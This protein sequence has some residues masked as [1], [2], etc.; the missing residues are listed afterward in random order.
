M[1]RALRRYAFRIMHREYFYVYIMSNR[2]RTLYT[3][4]TNNLQKRV[5][6]H[7]NHVYEGFTDRYQCDRLVY[8]EQLSTPEGGINREKQIKG[9]KRVRKV[10]LI[11]AQNPTWRDLS[12]DW[13]KPAQMTWCA[14][15]CID[16][17]LRSG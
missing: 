9:W 8:Y 11:V 14:E 13:G 7:K 5:W 1:S 10:A 16:P 12:D 3:G 17:S 4:Y 6:Q 15:K 2:S